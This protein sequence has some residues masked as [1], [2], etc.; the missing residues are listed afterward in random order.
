MNNPKYIILTVTLLLV[1]IAAPVYSEGYGFKLPD[2][3][4]IAEF[5]DWLEKNM[6]IGE[7]TD[8]GKSAGSSK[9]LIMQGTE[10]GETEVDTAKDGGVMNKLKSSAGG[11]TKEVSQKGH[12][13]WFDEMSYS[14]EYDFTRPMEMYDCLEYAL[15]GSCLSVR[16]S[17]KGPSF[18]H[19][20][21]V[22]HYVRDVHVETV[23]FAPME[24]PLKSHSDS[25]LPSSN[26][27]VEDNSMVYPLTWRVAKELGQQT[28]LGKVSKK[29]GAAEGQTIQNGRQRY[30]Y[31][32]AQ[33]S[34]N[35]E[36]HVFDTFA[37]NTIGMFGYCDSPTL[38]AAVYYN[39]TLDQF[40]WRW[41]ATTETVLTALYQGK[42][43]EWS[44]I[45]HSYGSTFP[46]LGYMNAKN[47]FQSSIVAAI[48]ATNI[49][50]ENRSLFSGGAGLHIFMPLPKYARNSFT[51]G[52]YKTPQ[53]ANTFKFDMVYPYVGADKGQRCT[54]YGSE[55]NML[56]KLS[57]NTQQEDD[58]YL[59]QF[60][61]GNG[62][63]VAAMKLYRP[64][65]CCKKRGSKVYSI[66]SPGSIGTP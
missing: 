35:I 51:G 14:A 64:F 52:K 45:G 6:D 2:L 44:D 60:N 40:S 17:W 42:E 1:A 4:K 61:E 62:H 53:T 12:W 19:G 11:V 24:S 31:T 54:R 23:P 25:V 48:R 43:M 47:R 22:E 66:V 38:P 63:N 33:V 13:D 30:T 15:V 49:A 41:L 46:R 16:W 27:I 56:G 10:G 65:R 21:A 39:S 9:D 37:K 20:F 55:K 8:V 50:A 26:S 32:D 36:R 57:I 3:G 7:I 34:G 59:K 28:M 58:N 5:G 18:T 29:L